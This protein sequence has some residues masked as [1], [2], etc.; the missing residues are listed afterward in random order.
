MGW[1]TV[2]RVVRAYGRPLVEDP[3][4]MAGVRGLGVDETAF[5]R[6][7]AVRSTQFVTGIVD[8][9]PGR[10]ARLLD[11][12]PGRSGTMYAAWIAK[13]EQAWRDRIAF[14]A[15]DPFRGYAAHRAAGRGAVLHAFHVVR[16]SSQALVKGQ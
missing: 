15:L 9:T 16:L 3:S 14:A 12:V 2:M 10:S 11:I 7:T 8:L 5:L 6:A 4:R 13:Q 1:G